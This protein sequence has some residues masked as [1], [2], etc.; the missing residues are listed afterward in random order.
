MFGS[1]NW[2]V[3][4]QGDESDVRFDK[5]VHVN[6]FEKLGL[7]V[8]DVA[9]GEY[10]SYALTDDGNVW[11]WGY[12]GKK[13]VFN[14][15][16]TQEIGALGHGDKE[17]QFVPKK[18]SFF[19][20]NDIKIKSIASG[21]YHCNA[22]STTGSMYSWGRGLYGVL[23]NGSNSHALEPMLNEEVEDLIV[24]DDE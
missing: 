22:I 11:T 23:G 20:D 9:L 16:Y 14:W 3:L 4:G 13:G 19:E 15:M 18:V 2:G 10:H 24:G 21:L 7:K 5:P 17:P 12:A 8:V 6:K 1:G